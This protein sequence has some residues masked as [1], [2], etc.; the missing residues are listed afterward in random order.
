MLFKRSLLLPW[1]L[2]FHCFYNGTSSCTASTTVLCL[3]CLYNSRLPH[4]TPLLKRY[5]LLHCFYNG[6]LSCTAS[7]T[8]SHIA[9]L[10][11]RYLLLHVFYNG[12]LSCA[13]SA[14]VP[15]IAPLLKRYLVLLLQRGWVGTTWHWHRRGS[16]SRAWRVVVMLCYV[17][18]QGVRFMFHTVYSCPSKFFFYID[19]FQTLYIFRYTVK[20]M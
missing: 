19:K 6:T 8:V 16:R 5:L 1:Y 14:T 20:T 17:M 3:H 11:K 15:H 18:W 10:S 9:P 12:T 7:A 2:I 4:L 13:A